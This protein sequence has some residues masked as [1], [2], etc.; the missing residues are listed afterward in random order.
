MKFNTEMSIDNIAFLE[1]MNHNENDRFSNSK[2]HLKREQGTHNEKSGLRNDT[3][4]TYPPSAL[5]QNN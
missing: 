4:K 5:Y 1:Y 2:S 3:P